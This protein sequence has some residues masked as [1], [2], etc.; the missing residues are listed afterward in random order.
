M[1]VVFAGKV[2]SSHFE[3]SYRMKVYMQAREKV[4]QHNTQAARGERTH[5]TEINKFADM[6]N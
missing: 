1:T 5:T 3:E 2:Y 6:V 4:A